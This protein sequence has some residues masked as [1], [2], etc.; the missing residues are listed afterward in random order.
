MMSEENGAPEPLQVGG[1]E[2]V[3]T[4]ESTETE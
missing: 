2:E 3:S 4:E 1:S